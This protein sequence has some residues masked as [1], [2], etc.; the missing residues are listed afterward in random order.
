MLLCSNS[1]THAANQ[2]EKRYSL[3]EAVDFLAEVGF[4]AIDVNF[5]KTTF[6][7]PE[8]RE[9]C[10]DGDN[11]Q[12]NMYRLKA[13]IKEKGLVAAL[14]HLPF[15]FDYASDVPVYEHPMMYRSIDACAILNIPYAVFHPLSSKGTEKKT[16]VE[17]TIQAYTPVAEYALKKG[18]MLAVENMKHTTAEELIG[19]SERLNCGVCWDTGHANYG[20]VKQG[21]S[22]RALGKRL[23]ALHINDNY[24]KGDNHTPPFLGTIDWM[25]V[26]GALREIEYGGVFNYEIKNSRVPESARKEYA[27]YLVKV[28]KYL[29]S[30]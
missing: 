21:E 29:L 16:L 22:L 3:F 27:E 7:S 24:G 6:Q 2:G 1:G 12:E 15:H 17:E 5:C 18:V 10:L 8:G 25:E 4:E 13:R 20:G 23:K 11:W 28:G 30:L 26:M 19:I 14:S 9:D